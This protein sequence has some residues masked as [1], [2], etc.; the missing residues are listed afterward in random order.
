MLGPD[1]AWELKWIATDP[2]SSA[3]RVSNRANSQ[4]PCIHR[5]RYR[6]A[7]EFIISRG[8]KI[9]HVEYEWWAKTGIEEEL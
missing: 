6:A 4:N 9:V 3:F 8:V 5:K 7:M 2:L 1:S